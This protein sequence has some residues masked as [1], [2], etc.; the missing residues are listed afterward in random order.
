MSRHSNTLRAR[1]PG[2]L[3]LTFDILG[4][5]PGGYHEVETL[6]QTIDLADELTFTF[7]P[8]EEFLVE[9]T[10]VEFAGPT[11]DVPLNQNNLIAKAAYLFRK[12][13]PEKSDCKVSVH[14]RKAVPVAGGMGGGSGNAAATLVA[15]NQ[16]FNSPLS[17][18]KIAEMASQLGADVPFFLNGGTQVGRHRGDVLS[19]VDLPNELHFLIVGPKLFG[20]QTAEVYGAY[21]ENKINGTT[22][23][24]ATECAEALKTGDNKNASIKFGNVF[25]H[26]VFSRRPELQFIRNRLSELG[27]LCTHMTG[28]GPT[29]YVFTT[30]KTEAE[31]IQQK[32]VNEQKN[33]INGW[34][35]HRDLVLNTWIATSTKHG[36]TLI[37]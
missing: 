27:G 31:C 29:L 32:L 5:L 30:D 21:D 1:S 33:A 28:S 17:D 24:S 16:W 2:K 15:L 22:T 26:I 36:V 8:A 35:N 14:L 25:E 9:I 13:F 6:M 19:K 4:D 3:N 37:A 7:E 11:G 23:I 10:S 12:K 20:L 18:S 34:N